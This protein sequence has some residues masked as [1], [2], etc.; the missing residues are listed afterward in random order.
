MR[1]HDP[2]VLLHDLATSEIRQLDAVI[3]GDEDVGWLH[4]QVYDEPGFKGV[5]CLLCVYLKVSRKTKRFYILAARWEKFSI[6]YF[7]LPQVILNKTYFGL[8]CF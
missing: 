8:N 2:R 1:G 7:I 6:K 4:V 5:T 3:T